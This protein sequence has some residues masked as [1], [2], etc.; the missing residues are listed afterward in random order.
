[1]GSPWKVMGPTLV[2]MVEAADATAVA[3]RKQKVKWTETR[4]RL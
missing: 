1:M 4:T 3:V 2:A